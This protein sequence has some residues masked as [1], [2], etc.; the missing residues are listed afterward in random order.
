M[1]LP[2]TITI[3][4]REYALESLSESARN[5]LM[6]LRLVDQEIS[7]LQMQLGIAQTARTVFAN[8]LKKNL[9]VSE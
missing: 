9:P 5:Q 7:R 2:K 1:D 4:N 6:N 3:D 8:G